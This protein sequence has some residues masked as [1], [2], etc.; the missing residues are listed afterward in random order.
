MHQQLPVPGGGQ[1]GLRY[2][3]YSL[4]HPGHTHAIQWHYAL[5]WPTHAA[6]TPYP[7]NATFWGCLEKHATNEAAAEVETSQN[8]PAYSPVSLL[9][10]NHYA[11]MKLTSKLKKEA[12]MA[13]FL[14]V[15][16]FILILSE[17]LCFSQDIPAITNDGRKVLLKQ[18]GT[19]KFYS[20][21]KQ[22]LTNNR[23]SQQ[24]PKESTSVFKAKGDKF[25]RYKIPN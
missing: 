23:N 4:L 18:D 10:Q 3:S 5:R 22:S 15:F 13:K 9:S 7:Y 11:G 14:C 8:A 25:Q 12:V 2:L 24:K 19:W 20:A 21:S 17:G 6:C 16:F 1:A